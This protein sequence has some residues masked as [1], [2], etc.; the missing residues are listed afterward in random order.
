[1]LQPFGEQETYAVAVKAKATAMVIEM[2]N[3]A[4]RYHGTWQRLPGSSWLRLRPHSLRMMPMVATS[5]SPLSAGLLS[6]KEVG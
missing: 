5:V 4:R 2:G 3:D 6:R 1:M